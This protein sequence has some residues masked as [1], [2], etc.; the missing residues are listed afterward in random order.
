[1]VITLPRTKAVFASRGARATGPSYRDQQPSHVS[2]CFN[3]SA[4]GNSYFFQKQWPAAG[5]RVR[6]FEELHGINELVCWAAFLGGFQ[7]R[8]SR[9]RWAIR[10]FLPVLSCSV[11]DIL[12][13]AETSRPQSMASRSISDWNWTDTKSMDEKLSPST[14]S[15]K[16]CKMSD[17]DVS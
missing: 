7:Q 2:P 17:L 11:T 14:A 15:L 8:Q 16:V 9:S 4:V 12:D 1:M 5:Q 6:A 13:S 3:V 10:R